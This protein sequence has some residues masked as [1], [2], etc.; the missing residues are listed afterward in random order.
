VGRAATEAFVFAFVSI[1]AIDFL[2]GTLLM[3]MY[4]VLWPM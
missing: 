3:R 2:L 4:F 1:L